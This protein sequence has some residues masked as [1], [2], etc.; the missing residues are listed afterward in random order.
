MLSLKMVVRRYIYIHTHTY[1]Y[2][3]YRSVPCHTIQ[4]NC[5]ALHC[6]TMQY[7]TLHIVCKCVQKRTNKTASS[8]G[9]HAFELCPC[10]VC[11]A[12]L[13][14][15][16]NSPWNAGVRICNLHP[17]CSRVQV[18]VPGS[19]LVLQ[20]T[21]LILFTFFGKKQFQLRLFW[22][23]SALSL[24]T[25]ARPVP[26]LERPSGYL[27]VSCLTA[28]LWCWPTSKYCH[29]AAATYSVK[30]VHMYVSKRHCHSI[31]WVF[32]ACQDMNEMRVFAAGH[33]PLNSTRNSRWSCQSPRMWISPKADSQSQKK[34]SCQMMSE[35][36]LY[37]RL[38]RQQHV[39]CLRL[40]PYLQEHGLD[41][42]TATL[43]QDHIK[44][45]V[46]RHCHIVIDFVWFYCLQSLDSR[47]ANM[48]MKSFT[49]GADQRVITQVRK[50]AN[51]FDVWCFSTPNRQ[52]CLSQLCI[53][54]HMG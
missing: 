41:V 3:P 42:D 19:G 45:V 21:C 23:S 35:F 34:P 53:F 40:S 30:Y 36:T 22:R 16:K 46:T 2:M 20:C 50:I 4:L 49:Q 33:L 6:T 51:R 10:G 13:W 7:I 5:I 38:R 14:L 48:P 31:Q 32:C 28:F 15:G 29:A 43:H 24:W 39:A 8:S 18:W 26:Q 44:L 9:L 25:L 11:R 1:S 47:P 12:G 27:S 17:R 54:N 52:R 37:F